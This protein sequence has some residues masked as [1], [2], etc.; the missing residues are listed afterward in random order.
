M[1]HMYTFVLYNLEF[2]PVTATYYFYNIYDL[3][4]EYHNN[5]T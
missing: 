2:H 3:S 5:L 4:S 1:S